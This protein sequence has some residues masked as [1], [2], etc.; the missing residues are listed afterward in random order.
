MSSSKKVSYYSFSMPFPSSQNTERSSVPVAK[1]YNPLSLRPSSSLND[2]PWCVLRLLATRCSCHPCPEIVF[3]IRCASP[4]SL[5]Q[6]FS[7]DRFRELASSLW[8]LAF[9]FLHRIFPK[10]FPAPSKHISPLGAEPLPR[11]PPFAVPL[12]TFRSLFLCNPHFL[13]HLLY[14]EVSTADHLSPPLS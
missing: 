11:W 5:T 9:S 13:P 12:T 4:H 2:N 14:K 7:P 8:R 10:H 1:R 6:A 3:R